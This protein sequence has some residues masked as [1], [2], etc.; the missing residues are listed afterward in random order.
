MKRL[1][2][3]DA[4]LTGELDEAAA[5][6]LEDAMFAAPDDG[7]LAFFDILTRRGAILDEHGT[8]EVGMLRE[9]VEALAARYRV[10]IQSS[11]PGK[12]TA[13]I[14]DDTELYCTKLLIGRTDLERVDVD[15]HI[16]KYDVSKTMRDVLV[17]QREGAIYGMCE[18][19][20]AMI[21]YGAGRAIV[22][23]RERGGE[24]RVIGEWD[25]TPA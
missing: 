9:Q 12:A 25:F 17:D 24:R 7:D 2:E 10:Q 13:S 8:F 11:A 22:K 3:L 16:A 20:L 18:R 19:P 23:V 21:A 14:A 15:I 1:H 6:A 4:Y 5:D